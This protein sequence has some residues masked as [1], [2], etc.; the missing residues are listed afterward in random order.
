MVG[1]FA[2]SDWK[3]LRKIRP[4]ALERLCQRILQ[5]TASLCADESQS[6]HQRYLNVYKHIHEQNKEIA[7][8]FDYDRR[9]YT[10]EQL[11]FF[12]ARDLISEEELSLFSPELQTTVKRITASFEQETDDEE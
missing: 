9:S 4:L 5:Q 10:L 8:G 2:E 3:R 11:S 7:L 1:T 12:H 6:H